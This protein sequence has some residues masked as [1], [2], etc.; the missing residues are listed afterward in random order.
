MQIQ[1]LF[2]STIISCAIIF[3]AGCS[4][5][6]DTNNTVVQSP[7][8][9][10][11]YTIN[12][13]VAPS[14][15]VFTNQST[16]ATSYLWD[17]G[18]GT[19]STEISPAHTYA[20]GGSFKVKLTAYKDDLDASKEIIFDIQNPYTSCKLKEIILNETP[21]V[22]TSGGDWDAGSGPD[23]KF[24]MLLHNTSTVLFT[25]GIH[26]DVAPSQLP[27][28]FEVNPVYQF[29]DFNQEYDVLLYDDDAPA[30]DELVKG[31]FFKLSD[32]TTINYHYPDTMLLYQ[33]GNNAKFNLVLEWGY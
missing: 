32:A 2:R 27:V 12:G 13:Y 10:Y 23:F 21:F 9:A 31:Y 16:N 1:N 30:A 11:K 7:G 8:V 33:S 5:E 19:T 3:S 22:N 4:K 6:D 25:S 14:Q 28:S 26:N 20:N 15:I 29:P 24:K 17:F 18:D